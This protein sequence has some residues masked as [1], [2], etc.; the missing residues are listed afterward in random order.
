MF[1]KIMAFFDFLLSP[2]PMMIAAAMLEFIIRKFPTS[3]PKSLLLAAKAIL[4]GVGSVL[5]KVSEWLDK[6]VGQSLK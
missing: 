1:A 5:G 6:L 3:N 4:T 2:V